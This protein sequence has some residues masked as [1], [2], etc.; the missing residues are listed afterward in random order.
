M[1][2]ESTTVFSELKLS[3]ILLRDIQ[4]LKFDLRVSKEQNEQ[5]EIVVML[6]KKKKIEFQKEN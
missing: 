1:L 2:K 4:K 6:M 3:E 5:N